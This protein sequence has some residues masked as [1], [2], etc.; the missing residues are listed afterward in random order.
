MIKKNVTEKIHF[1]KKQSSTTFYEFF[2][3]DPFP[4]H[5]WVSYWYI[6]GK[7]DNFLC[8]EGD[9]ES[10][11]SARQPEKQGEDDADHLQ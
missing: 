2:L 10:I 8:S 5:R 9:V 4:K 1:R 3:L 6:I 7:S 11:K